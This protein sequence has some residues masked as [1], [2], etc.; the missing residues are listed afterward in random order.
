M[1]NHLHKVKKQMLRYIIQRIYLLD[2]MENQFLIGSINYM[3]WEFSTNAK[4]VVTIV[5]GDVVRLRCISNN[6]DILTE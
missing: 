4:Y 1:R 6:G 3:G 2:G 5:I